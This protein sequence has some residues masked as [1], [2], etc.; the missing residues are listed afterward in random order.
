M[1]FHTLRHYY[2]SPLIQSGESV[3]AVQELLGHASAVETLD[4]YGH[5]WPGAD[6]R[7]RSALD[8]E[9]GDSR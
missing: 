7:I 4:T 1:T 9:F 6:D 2:A 5:L 8:K 3:K